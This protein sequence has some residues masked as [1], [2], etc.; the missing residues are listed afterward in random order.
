MSKTN[1]MMRN[2]L[3]KDMFHNDGM[4]VVELDQKSLNA[5]VSIRHEDGHESPLEVGDKM[6]IKIPNCLTPNET[7]QDVLVEIAGEMGAQQILKSMRK[8]SMVERVAE[9]MS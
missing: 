5:E 9:A 7:L 6:L 3:I 4:V 2:R 1:E 8:W